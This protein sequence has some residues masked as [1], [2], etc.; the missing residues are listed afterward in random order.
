MLRMAV[1]QEIIAL[2]VF[3][4]AAILVLWVLFAL[5]KNAARFVMVILANSLVGLV[6]LA[7]LYVLGVKVPLTAPVIVSIALFGLGGLGTIL[8]FLLFG[9]L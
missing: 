6:A 9:G 4:A 8:V 3:A 5:L 2:A 1:L 7:L